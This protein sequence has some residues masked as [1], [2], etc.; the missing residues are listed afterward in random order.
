M[1]PL[2]SS[3]TN[4]DSFGIPELISQ[5]G[6]FLRSKGKLTQKVIQTQNQFTHAHLQQQ[7]VISRAI[8]NRRIKDFMKVMTLNEANP[9]RSANFTGLYSILLFKRGT[10]MLRRRK[11][12]LKGNFGYGF[13]PFH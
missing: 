8:Q 9:A 6:F 3:R 1:L 12:Q 13:T 2:E 10:K 4:I 11:A 7:R 5:V